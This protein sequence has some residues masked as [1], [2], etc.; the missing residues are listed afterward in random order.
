M[1]KFSTKFSSDQLQDYDLTAEPI[2]NFLNWYEQAKHLE[3]NPEAMTLAT[4]DGQGRVNARIVLYKGISENCF[5]LYGHDCSEKGQHLA[6]NPQASLVFYWHNLKRQVRIWGTV[7]K[8]SD[9]KV[10]SY[11]QKRA[12]E[13][14]V[15]SA[16]SKQSS[17]ISG[18]EE[19]ESRFYEALEVAKK[20]GSVEFPKTWTGYLLDPMEMEFFLYRE[21]RLN[22]RFLFSKHESIWDVKRLQP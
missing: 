22:D 20:S 10:Q 19:L 9:D 5:T 6:I 3:E 14:Q 18:R 11:F 21:Y 13:S 15:A 17:E 12:L 1:T 16:I 2:H 8:M 7:K 4:A